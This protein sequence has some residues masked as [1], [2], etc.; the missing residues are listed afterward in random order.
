LI[1]KALLTIPASRL[2]FDRDTT[3][4]ALE[5]A[6]A[7]L[8]AEPAPAA[9]KTFSLRGEQVLELQRLAIKPTE[10]V[11]AIELRITAART[12]FQT[13]RRPC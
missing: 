4:A 10:P 6:C 7:A 5:L 1:S 13:A 3:G 11:A 9:E 8:N 12:L 2:W